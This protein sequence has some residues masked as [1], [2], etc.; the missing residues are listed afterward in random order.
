LFIIEIKVAALR[1]TKDGQ[2]VEFEVGQARK[3][4]VPTML[5]L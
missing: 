4:S 1:N 2:A 5:N 3:A